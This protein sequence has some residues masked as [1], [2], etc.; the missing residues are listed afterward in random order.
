MRGN[1]IVLITHASLAQFLLVDVLHICIVLMPML[2]YF[3][4][5][6][7]HS[8]QFNSN[9]KINALVRLLACLAS[10]IIHAAEFDISGGRCRQLRL[11]GLSCC[12]H[13]THRWFRFLQGGTFDSRS[14]CATA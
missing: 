3:L 5:Q 1:A 13:R 11:R 2:H 4:H 14:T 8:Y 12:F 7:F 10:W 6:L 9:E